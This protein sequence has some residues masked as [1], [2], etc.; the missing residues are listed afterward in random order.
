VA[1]LANAA[2]CSAG[3]T[4]GKAASSAA[5][6]LASFLAID[7]ADA[8][9]AISLDSLLSGASSRYSW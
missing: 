8:P 3:E 2:T 4:S 9:V 1:D 5:F 6:C 7:W